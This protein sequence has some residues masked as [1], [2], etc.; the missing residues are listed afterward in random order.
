MDT[1]TDRAYIKAMVNIMSIETEIRDVH[2]KFYEPQHEIIIVEGLQRDLDTW[3][4]ILKL[5]ENESKG[6]SK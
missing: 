4:L 6:N 1:V 3:K 5:I 2:K